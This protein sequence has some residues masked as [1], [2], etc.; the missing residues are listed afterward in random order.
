LVSY[1]KTA[2]HHNKDDYEEE[3][4]I[5]TWSWRHPKAHISFR[6]RSMV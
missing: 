6:F 1:H 3:S 4:Y 2:L 5:Y